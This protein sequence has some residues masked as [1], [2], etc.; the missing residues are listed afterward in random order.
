MPCRYRDIS[1]STSGNHLLPQSDKSNSWPRI[2]HDKCQWRNQNLLQSRERSEDGFTVLF[3]SAKPHSY[4]PPEFLDTGIINGGRS[5]GTA[6]VMLSK[7]SSVPTATPFVRVRAYL[8]CSVLGF[9]KIQ[10]FDIEIILEKIISIFEPSYIYLSFS[11]EY[12]VQ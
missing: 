1:A 5:L 7:Q 4:L 12:K 2:L 3:F 6:G 11:N 9:G 8:H 10:Q